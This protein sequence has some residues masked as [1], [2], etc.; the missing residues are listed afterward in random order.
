[1]NQIPHPNVAVQISMPCRPDDQN[2]PDPSIFAGMCECLTLARL[3]PDISQK[4]DLR[5]GL[6]PTASNGDLAST[7]PK[8]APSPHAGSLSYSHHLGHP[9][10]RRSSAAWRRHGGRTLGSRDSLA[11][12]LKWRRQGGGRRRGRWLRGTLGPARGLPGTGRSAAAP[13]RLG[14]RQ[15]PRWTCSS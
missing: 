6:P 13:A 14:E 12:L 2:A 15:P 7:T 8:M 9:A 1:M 5:P 11:E 10:N 4:A 3:A